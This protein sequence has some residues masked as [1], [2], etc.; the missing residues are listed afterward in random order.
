MCF[1]SCS[2]PPVALANH[3]DLAPTLP[4][5][6]CDNERAS[7]CKSQ[8]ESQTNAGT[9]AADRQAA[10][11]LTNGRCGKVVPPSDKVIPETVKVVPAED[12]VVPPTNKIVPAEVKVVL[13]EDKVVPLEGRVVPPAD[14]KFVAVNTRPSDEHVHSD[15]YNTVFAL[16]SLNATDATWTGYLNQAR[17]IWQQHITQRLSTGEGRQGA[18]CT[19]RQPLASPPASA[20]PATAAAA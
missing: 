20:S 14:N 1:I 4:S 10:T 7:R 15:I 3:A 2:L 5:M 12:K 8:N 18:G 16:Q 9:V 19:G 11:N 13:T 6:P 17:G